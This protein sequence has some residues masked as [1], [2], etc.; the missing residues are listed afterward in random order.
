MPAFYESLVLWSINQGSIIS[1]YSKEKK[2][3]LYIN[4]AVNNRIF[5][6]VMMLFMSASMLSLFSP[7]RLFD[8]LWTVA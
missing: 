4:G 2:L 5:N 1:S 7:A 3:S 8:T 6:T